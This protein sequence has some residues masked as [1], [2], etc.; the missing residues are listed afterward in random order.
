MFAITFASNIGNS[1]PLNV[2]DGKRIDLDGATEIRID[3]ELGDVVSAQRVGNDLVLIMS[4]GSEIVIGD[5]D[6]SIAERLES[7]VVFAD[8]AV[9]TPSADGFVSPAFAESDLL[10]AGLSASALAMSAG[11]GDVVAEDAALAKIAAYADNNTQPAPTVQEIILT[12]M[13]A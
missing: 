10:V 3:A 7:R 11:G 4:D 9:L 1:Q 13:L 6:Q 12:G 8:G 2:G 5:F